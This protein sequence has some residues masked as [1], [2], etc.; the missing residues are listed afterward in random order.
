MS[1]MS[2]KPLSNR[3]VVKRLE[4]KTQT[5][6]GIIIPDNVKEK[7]DQGIVE[8]VGPGKPLENGSVQAMSLN[9]GDRVIF[10]KYAGTEVTLDDETYVI[11]A[12]TDVLG[13]VQS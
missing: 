8:A 7:P 13:V 9:E 6:G 3:V 2:I 12:E 11:M 10:G 4:E 1:T 5:S